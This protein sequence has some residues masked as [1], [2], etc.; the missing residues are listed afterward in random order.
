MS[1]VRSRW[2]GPL[3]G[4]ML[5]LADMVFYSALWLLGRGY[6]SFRPVDPPP[7]LAQI[8]SDLSIWRTWNWLHAPVAEVFGPYLFPYF[9]V[10]DA[11]LSTIVAVSAY[12]TLCF[13]QMFAI[14]FIGG[15]LIQKLRSLTRE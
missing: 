1:K 3:L 15:M 4:G 14:G 10:H 11:S 13:V 5:A 2:L 8:D 7:T 9:K 12:L 6:I